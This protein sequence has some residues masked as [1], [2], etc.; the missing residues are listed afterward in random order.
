MTPDERVRA[1]HF[2]AVLRFLSGDKMKNATLCERL[3][4]APKNA[5]QATTVINRTLEAGLIR[6][7]DP[8]IHVPAMCL[9][10]HKFLDRV[11]ILR[12][13]NAR[14]GHV[15]PLRINGLRS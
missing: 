2:H 3:G 8:P 9:I 12:G 6:A 15:R 10:G 1:C 5:A 11:L 13:Q 14:A 4:I 7:A